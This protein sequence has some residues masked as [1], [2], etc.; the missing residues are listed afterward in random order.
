MQHRWA[1]NIT[2]IPKR[3]PENISSVVKVSSFFLLKDVSK[4]TVTTA[5]VTTVT[6]TIVTIVT[7][8]T[9]TTDLVKMFMVKKMF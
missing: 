4:T 1:E 8:T 3:C 6:I 9:V 5:T 2:R 7:V